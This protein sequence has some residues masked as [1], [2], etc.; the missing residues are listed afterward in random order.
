MTTIEV[1]GV[2]YWVREHCPQDAEAQARTPLLL[3]HGFTGSSANWA[4]F[5]PSFGRRTVAPDLLGHGQTAAPKAPARYAMENA[6]ADVAALIE[7]TVAEPVHLLG[8]SMGGR[9]ALYFALTY[10]DRVK[11][12][13]L[14]SAS[15]GLTDPAERA[16]RR[17]A[18]ET[19]ATAIEAD[20]IDAFV[21]RWERLPLFASQARLAAPVRAAL[22]GQ[23]LDNDPVGLSGSLRGMGTGVQPSCW[24]WL[25]EIDR[26][27]LLIAGA[28]D[29]KFCALNRRM[30]AC[31]PDVRLSIIDNAGHT[32]HLEAPERFQR[33]VEKFLEERDS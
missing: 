21:E 12:L 26:P 11:T 16:Q 18:D 33:Q 25:H 30:Q 31:M 5:M 2:R 1:G 8:Y 6:A 10:P 28:L 22:R 15:P 4:E 14:E 32:V 13:T 29:A 17:A 20:G 3:L 27:T 7:Q 19:L 24:S 23:R 9:L